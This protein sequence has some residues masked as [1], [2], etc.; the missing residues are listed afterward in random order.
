MQKKWITRY[1]LPLALVVLVAV[2]ALTG[3][4]GKQDGGSSQPPASSQQVQATDIGEGQTVFTFQV[5]DNTQKVSAWNVHT[6][7]TTVGA[8]LAEL[9]LIKGDTSEFGLMVTEVN[10][11]TA[12]YNADKAYWAFFIDGQYAQTGVDSTNIEAGKVYAFV[13]TKE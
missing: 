11:L 9:G 8:A 10:G 5:T 7:K 2:T 4:D 6:D 12:D 3:C 1:L 13:Y